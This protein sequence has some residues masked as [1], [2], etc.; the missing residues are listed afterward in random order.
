MTT[1]Q[2]DEWQKRA[3]KRLNDSKG[4]KGERSWVSKSEITF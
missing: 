2:A 4:Q 1:G 3:Q